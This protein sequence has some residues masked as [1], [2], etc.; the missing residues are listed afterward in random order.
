MLETRKSLYELLVKNKQTRL[1]QQISENE[2]AGWKAEY[3]FF[4]FFV[5]GQTR[6]IR[7]QTL[8]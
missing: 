6:E 5:K 3:I 7:K 2:K 4:S 8:R 1:F